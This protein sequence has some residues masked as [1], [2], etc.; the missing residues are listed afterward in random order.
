MQNSISGPFTWQQN[1]CKSSKFLTDGG[2]M[3][4]NKTMQIIKC[5]Q[6]GNSD[7]SFVSKAIPLEFKTCGGILLY[8]FWRRLS[9]WATLSKSYSHKLL[10]TIQPCNILSLT[11]YKLILK[12]KKKKKL[13]SKK[14]DLSECVLWQIEK[15]C[16][17]Q[18][19]LSATHL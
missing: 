8:T 16:K 6:C 12:K 17:W 11:Y 1:K 7:I 14:V 18:F 13:S 19:L 3:S 10:K 5:L 2:S 15:L 4:S 9:V